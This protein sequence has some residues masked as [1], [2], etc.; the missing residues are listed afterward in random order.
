MPPPQ[1]TS[2][3]IT[4]KQVRN[5][6]IAAWI[7]LNGLALAVA[8][9]FLNESHLR[10]Q[11][12][13]VIST[14]NLAQLLEQQIENTYT[15]ADI[16]L[17]T[18]ADEF[19]RQIRQGRI[20]DAS[21]NAFITRQ[22]DRRVVL[23]SLRVTDAEGITRWG[24]EFSNNPNTSISDRDYFT[25]LKAD[26]AAPM[27]VSKPLRGK[28]SKQE[29]LVLAR[30]L[31]RPDGE[32]AGVAYATIGV[33]TFIQ[34]FRT[35]QLGERGSIALRDH[36]LILIAR[37]PALPNTPIGS[38]NISEDFRQALLS[39]PPN[40]TYISGKTSLDGISRLHSYRKNL[41]Y[42][43][44]INVG[45][46]QEDYLAAWE[47][48]LHMA[49]FVLLAFAL[50]SAIGF[51]FIFR[52]SLGVAQ[53]E[54]LLS[55]I[56]DV[57]D[58]A[59]FLVNTHGTVTH[60]N[61]RM[62]SMWE[63][64]H[65]E[66]IGSNYADLVHP[67]QRDTAMQHLRK[68]VNSE[69]PFVRIE[70][71]YLRKNNEPFWGFLCGRQLRDTEGKLLGLVGLI[72]DIS[73]QKK[74]QIELEEHRQHLEVLVEKRTAELA[75]AKEAAESANRA[76]SSFLANMS[77]EIRTPMNAIIGLTHLLQ[78]D[79]PSP[80]QSDRLNKIVNSAH[81]L[82]RIINDIL[83][84]SK[85]ESGKL[86]LEQITFRTSDLVDKLI[87]QNQERLQNKGLSFQSHLGHLPPIVVGDPVRISQALLNY[88][89]NAIK[90]TDTGC[91][92]LTASILEE[93]E[94][95]LLARF[96]VTDSGIG[97]SPDEQSRLFLPFEQADSS[98]TRKYG[99][100]GLGLS[101]TRRLAELMGGSAGLRSTPGAGSTF[102]ITVRLGKAPYQQGDVPAEATS[103]LPE[104]RLKHQYADSRILLVEDDLINQEVALELLHEIAGL[105]VQV[106]ANGKIAVD[107]A[108]QGHFD[109]ILMDLLMPELDG[110]EATR[111]IRQLP[112]HARI[113]IIAMTANAF[114]KDKEICLQAG[115]NDHIPKPVDPDQLFN[116][117]LKWLAHKPA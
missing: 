87:N 63:I 65:D 27:I 58:G 109:L 26:P 40:T 110:I 113:P 84:L 12:R 16:A 23:S 93:N 89:S 14:Q 68:L 107:L 38:Q 47:Q 105:D 13:A 94:N 98:T 20:D 61:Q 78:R 59:I 32:F 101:I 5:R 15:R 96:E 48:E 77:H 117:L 99:G 76:K 39:P 104:L 6:F 73:E 54:R 28:I 74:T 108:R 41:L 34:H 43:F 114:D 116:T 8:S 35:L 69:I 85:I 55:T 36:Q 82:L 2:P 37:T 3:S 44:Y 83:D 25:R 45:M 1:Q 112:S 49:G 64:P 10:H 75:Q 46:S 52:T 88:L 97:I 18:I 102:W 4:P 62:A 24:T 51:F 86:Q 66:L 50:I 7:F 103:N 106:A 22:R 67:E 91:I 53:G 81:H 95:S 90:F 11:E 42:G 92:Q 9:V 29:V 31:N 72:S 115:M 19:S 56:F 17:M 21:F 30:R 79:Q 71:K 80:G 70:R 33:E 60:A 100:T 57:S 111:Q